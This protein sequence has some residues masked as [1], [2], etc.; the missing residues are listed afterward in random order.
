MLHDLDPPAAVNQIPWRVGF[1]DDI[2]LDRCEADGTII[3]SYSP[4]AGGKLAESGTLTSQQ[5]LLSKI[6]KSYGRNA[7]IAQV[8]LRYVIENKVA[9]VSKT[10]NSEFVQ[11]DVAAFHWSS[12]LKETELL[13][14]S[15][16]ST[17]SAEGAATGA[18]AAA[19]MCQNLTSGKMTRCINLDRHA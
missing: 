6:S 12:P 13:A 1:H 10:T 18:D 19:M 4:L 11:D 14:L 3:Q 8:A 5:R 16:L 9:F 7:S 17:P 2:L 15:R